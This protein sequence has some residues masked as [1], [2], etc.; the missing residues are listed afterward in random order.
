MTGTITGQAMVAGVVGNPVAH[1]LS[2]A[3]HNAW[4]AAASLDAAYVP[5]PVVLSGFKAFIHGLRGGVLRG[6]NVTI[7]FKE[8]ALQIADAASPGAERAG[9]ANLLLFKPDGTIFADNTDGAGLLAALNTAQGFDVRAGPAV[10][11]G[12][13]GAARGAVAALLSAGAPEVR[14]V[15]RTQEK[16]RAVAAELGALAADN[17]SQAF[18]GANC[19]INATSLG[20]N[21]AGR[22]DIPWNSLP[23]TA[24]VMDMVYK[25]LRT[26]FL[27]DAMLRGRTTVDGLA[28]LIGQAVPSFAAFFGQAPPSIDVRDVAL[29]QLE[30]Q[31]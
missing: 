26:P 7:P 13:G 30:S 11:L 12:A 5:L 17:K 28:M 18:D 16:A 27:E 22:P 10:V 4:I 19:V 14:L 2:P 1:S 15:N 8:E 25:P 23:P 24:V 20:L 6:V 31:T 29:R 9:A 3:I 21:G